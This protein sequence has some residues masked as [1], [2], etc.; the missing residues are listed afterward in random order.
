[1]EHYLFRSML[2]ENCE[3]NAVGADAVGEMELGDDIFSS[4]TRVVCDNQEHENQSG[5][6]QYLK[7]DSIMCLGHLLR[8]GKRDASGLTVYD[9][10]GLAIEDLALAQYVFENSVNIS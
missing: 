6:M 1:M 9:S 4:P 10:T 8:M 5:E 3:S 7:S 2:T